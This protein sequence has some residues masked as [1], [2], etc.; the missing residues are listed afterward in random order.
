MAMNSLSMQW[1]ACSLHT[2]GSEA[3]RRG[4]NAGLGASE[5][6]AVDGRGA[7]LGRDDRD[8]RLGRQ[9]SRLGVPRHTR[10]ASQLRWSQRLPGS[11]CLAGN[12]LHT[13]S[14][15]PSFIAVPY[16]KKTHQV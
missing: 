13:H 3:Y 10:T 8:G 4:G 15:S 5:V 1:Y 16:M 11:S 12:N 6:C 14:T 9:R 2:I 7:R